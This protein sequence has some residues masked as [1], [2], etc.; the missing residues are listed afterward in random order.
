[1]LNWSPWSSTP[2]VVS[3]PQHIAHT[4]AQWHQTVYESWSFFSPESK[5]IW[6][7]ENDALLIL[8]CSA[9]KKN[10]CNRAY[11]IFSPNIYPCSFTWVYYFVGNNTKNSGGK[12]VDVTPDQGQLPYWLCCGIVGIPFHSVVHCAFPQPNCLHNVVCD[13]YCPLFSSNGVLSLETMINTRKTDM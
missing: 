6:K 2:R 5:R 9:Q 7:T 11:Y 1:M 8:F 4:L 3:S 12:F 10:D 13:F